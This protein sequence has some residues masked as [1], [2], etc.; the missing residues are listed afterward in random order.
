MRKVC[1]VVYDI[2]LFES[3]KQLLSDNF[4]LEEVIN[5]IIIDFYNLNSS[6]G[7]I[8]NER[9]FQKRQYTSRFL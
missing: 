6:S 1:D 2:P 8:G 7:F 4:V 9:A 3:L 5:D